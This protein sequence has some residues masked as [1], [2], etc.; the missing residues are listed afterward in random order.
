MDV[1]RLNVALEIDPMAEPV[2]GTV[3]EHE[4]PAQ[5]FTGWTQLGRILGDII[6]AHAGGA[7]Q[8]TATEPGG[9][10]G[11]ARALASEERTP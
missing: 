2:T 1:P 7:A 9:G 6:A 3:R 5:T 10:G 4:R 8:D 11:A